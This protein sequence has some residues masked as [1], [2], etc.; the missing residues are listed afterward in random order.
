VTR[1]AICPGE[2]CQAKVEVHEL[3]DGVEECNFCCVPCFQYTWAQISGANE[4][5]VRHS[6]QC[7]GRQLARISEP[8]TEGDFRISTP[9]IVPH[10]RLGGQGGSTV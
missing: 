5:R 4:P 1:Y 7:H 10:S 6:D 9:K 2:D 8:V 3:P